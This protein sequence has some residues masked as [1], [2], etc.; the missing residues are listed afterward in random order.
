MSFG[1]RKNVIVDRV[2][3]ISSRINVKYIKWIVYVYCCWIILM[4]YC[5]IVED[6]VCG[7]WGWWRLVDSICIKW[8]DRREWVVVI[9]YGC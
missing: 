2:K 3:R 1:V 4:V 8:D 7:W 9:F 6:V 5:S